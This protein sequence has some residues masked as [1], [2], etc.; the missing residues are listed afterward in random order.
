VHERRLI[1][2]DPR[3]AGSIAFHVYK[4]ENP[5][6][7]YQYVRF[8]ILDKWKDERFKERLISACSTLPARASR[9]L[10]EL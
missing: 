10:P 7:N 5:N 4:S 3:S 1:L 9:S 6:R 2:A 8:Y